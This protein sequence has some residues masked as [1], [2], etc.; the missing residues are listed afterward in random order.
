MMR[1]ASLAPVVEIDPTPVAVDA[2]CNLYRCV[3]PLAPALRALGKELLELLSDTTV[4][5]APVS[6]LPNQRSAEENMPSAVA[7]TVRMFT[8]TSKTDK[9]PVTERVVMRPL[10]LTGEPLE[11]S[12]QSVPVALLVVG[13]R[14]HSTDST[15]RFARLR[16]T[17]TR[18]YSVSRGMPRLAS[19]HDHFP[20]RQPAPGVNLLEP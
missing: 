20:Q 17:D 9:H 6:P 2:E 19:G 10:T 13:R 5:S 7:L 8:S 4:E 12:I 15:V 1:V 14:Q 16:L 3:S 18:C 11:H